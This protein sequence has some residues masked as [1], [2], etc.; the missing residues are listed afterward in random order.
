M[1]SKGNLVLQTS[2]FPKRW[3]NGHFP[4]Q[5]KEQLTFNHTP[6][7]QW[8]E[9]NWKKSWSL[10]Y[11][12]VNIR[13]YRQVSLNIPPLFL[14][15]NKSLHIQWLLL[16]QR[17]PFESFSLSKS[18]Y[19]TNLDLPEIRGLTDFPCDL[20]PFGSFGSCEVAII[21]IW[22]DFL[23]CKDSIS[24]SNGTLT[25]CICWSFNLRLATEKHLFFSGLSPK[26]RAWKFRVDPKKIEIV[27][28]ICWAPKPKKA[29]KW[30]CCP[31]KKS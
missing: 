10:P 11:I 9:F 3:L 19:F 24:G 5:K 6:N 21:I 30:K 12:S 4:W 22:P 16:P 20:L 14:R 18:S 26:K 1:F 29:W 7:N 25:T 23:C 15:K 2:I 27:P 31:T 8:I 28:S 17:F 13:K